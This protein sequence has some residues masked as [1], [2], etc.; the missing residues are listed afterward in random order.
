MKVRLIMNSS[1]RHWDINLQL[2]LLS[3]LFSLLLL[4]FGVEV[5]NVF[6]RSSQRKN[7]G[8][9]GR[10][11]SV[12]IAM[13]MQCCVVCDGPDGVVPHRYYSY[14]SSLSLEYPRNTY[15]KKKRRDGGFQWFF[16]DLVTFNF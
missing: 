14:S 2:E 15:R 1:E 11:D 6:R 9:F 8:E 7:G 12:L 16:N 13:E 4:L 5:G 3:M 10:E